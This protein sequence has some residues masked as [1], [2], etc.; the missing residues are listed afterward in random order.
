MGP[1]NHKS[2]TFQPKFEHVDNEHNSKRAAGYQ[3]PYGNI[4]QARGWATLPHYPESND[5]N[6][7]IEATHGR[8]SVRSMHRHN[9]EVGQVSVHRVMKQDFRTPN[10]TTHWADMPV[11]RA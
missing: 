11:A 1:I 9:R 4:T 3:D 7:L 2:T 10:Y 5:L 6:E 8:I